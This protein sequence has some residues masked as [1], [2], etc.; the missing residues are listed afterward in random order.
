MAVV[1]ISE[2]SVYLCQTTQRN[3]P[4]DFNLH[5]RRRENL[6]LYSE[7]SFLLLYTSDSCE[8]FYSFTESEEA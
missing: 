5:S 2:T 1:N 7:N 3:I 8:K 4:Q 6:K